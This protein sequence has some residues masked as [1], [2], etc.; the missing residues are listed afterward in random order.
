MNYPNADDYV[1]AYLPGL[2]PWL[3]ADATG[4]ARLALG[5]GVL[6]LNA[7]EIEE[8]LAE[9][10]R[11]TFESAS[12]E[13]LTHDLRVRVTLPSGDASEFVAD[14]IRY[15]TLDVELRMQRIRSR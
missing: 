8:V 10:I 4:G 7:L 11:L 5:S 15:D 13:S 1:R 3:L 2:D 14:D 9:T 6:D 12:A